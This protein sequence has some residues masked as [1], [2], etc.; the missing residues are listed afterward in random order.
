MPFSIYIE[1]ENIAYMRLVWNDNNNSKGYFH[2]MLY[3][4]PW[5]VLICMVIN[6]KERKN[7]I[8][9]CR[10]MKIE[11]EHIVEIWFYYAL[12]Y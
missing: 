3:T 1:F 2:M 10:A 12:K 11:Q 7:C 9:R 8:L 4:M 5:A 6:A